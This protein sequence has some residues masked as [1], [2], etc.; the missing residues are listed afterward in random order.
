MIEIRKTENYVDWIDN[1]RDHQARARVLA[2]IERLAL[3]NPGDVKPV[4]EGVSELRIDFG[5]GYRVYFMKRGREI[6]ILLAGGDKSTQTS[7][8]RIAL[9]LARNL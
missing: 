5:P 7:D 6:V 9:R 1:L 2:R 8:I 4:G 3:G